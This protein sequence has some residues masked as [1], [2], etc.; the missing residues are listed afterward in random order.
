MSS[1]SQRFSR[2]GGTFLALAAAMLAGCAVT[3]GGGAQP[4]ALQ[5]SGTGYRV[6]SGSHASRFPEREEVGRVCRA[7][8]AFHAIY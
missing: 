8:A 2:V 5:P 1:T 7:S 6:C 4:L 3:S